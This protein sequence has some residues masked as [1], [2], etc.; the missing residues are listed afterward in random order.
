LTEKYIPRSFIEFREKYPKIAR[1]YDEL[2]K[3]A[4]EAGPLDRKMVELV[5][6]GMSIALGSEGAVKSHVRRAL[7]E[8][9]LEDEILHVVLL[10]ITTLGWPRAHTSYTWVKEVLENYSPR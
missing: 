10:A 4:I 9:A 8:G 5:K 2:G 3:T 7:E 1:L 6:L